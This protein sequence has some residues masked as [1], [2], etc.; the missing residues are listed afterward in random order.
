M[1]NII[2]DNI[3][4]IILNKLSSIRQIGDAETFNLTI[5]QLFDGE[6]ELFTAVKEYSEQIVNGI[7]NQSLPNE[8][9]IEIYKNLMCIGLCGFLAERTA[10]DIIL[11]EK[12]L[13]IISRDYDSVEEYLTRKMNKSKKS[14]KQIVTEESE[15]HAKSKSE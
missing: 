7:S 4:K 13:D 12:T 9:R 5:E 3:I 6:V 14:L 2:T 11:D 8:A 15:K 10:R 1:D